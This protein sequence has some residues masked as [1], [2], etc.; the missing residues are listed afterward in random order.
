VVRTTGRQPEV[1]RSTMERSGAK[2][3]SISW[4]QH[5]VLILVVLVVAARVVMALLALAATPEPP[6]CG[7]G[8]DCSTLRVQVVG[9]PGPQSH[10]R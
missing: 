3:G 6:S 8:E 7:D 4:Q 5:I 9:H 10:L 1:R 2:P